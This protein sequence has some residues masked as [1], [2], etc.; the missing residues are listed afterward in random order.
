MPA[1]PR[2]YIDLRI[3]TEVP[4]PRWDVVVMPETIELGADQRRKL[5]RQHRDLRR[6]LEATLSATE[7]TESPG[8]KRLPVLVGL[9]L[10]LQNMLERHATFEEAVLVPHFLVVDPTRVDRLIND[11]RR[12]RAELSVLA[13]LAFQNVG[14]PRVGQAFRSLI[15]NILAEMDD[16]ERELFRGVRRRAKSGVSAR[17]RTQTGEYHGEPVLDDDEVGEQRASAARRGSD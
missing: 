4:A 7:D 9:A 17:K 16:E 8:M 11:H 13:K 15:R 6:V 3:L 10:R 1:P 5:L 14:L 12:Q 2:D